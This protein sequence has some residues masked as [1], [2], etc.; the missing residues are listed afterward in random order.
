MDGTRGAARQWI[1]CGVL[2]VTVVMVAGL[3]ALLLLLLV[4]VVAV[5]IMICV[6]CLSTPA[7]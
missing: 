4:V 6:V 7:I 2:R 3:L 5:A 1:W